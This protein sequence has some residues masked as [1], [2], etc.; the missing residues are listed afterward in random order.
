[1]KYAWILW[2]LAG[3]AWTQPATSEDQPID[4]DLAFRVEA[5]I[6]R[7]GVIE[8]RWKVAEGY[9]L[10]RKKLQI[11][12]SPASCVLEGPELPAG[13]LKDDEYFGR[14]EVYRE[15]FAARLRYSG[16]EPS[17]IGV[18]YQGCGDI[19]VCFPPV[20]RKL[21]L[22]VAANAPGGSPANAVPTSAG[23]VLAVGADA[24]E[25]EIEH[26][27]QGGSPALILISFFGF[28]L[29]L[30]L[31]PCVFPMIPILSGI[32]VKQGGTISRFRAALL[33]GTYVLGMALTY[34]LAGVAAGLSGTMISGALQNPW[35]L[36][37]FAALFVALALSMFGSFELQLPAG[38][39]NRLSAASGNRGGSLGG[40]ALMGALS[41]LIVGPCIAPPLAG[42]LLYI[43]KTGDARL[44]GIALFT[45][46]LGMGVPLMLV[47]IFSREILPKA[48][49]WMNAVTK[50]FGV[51]LLATALWIVSPV[52][53]AWALMLCGAALLIMTAMFL[54]AL[55]PLPPNANGWLRAWKGVGVVFL[56]VGG[57]LLIG[58]L[59]G[60][61]DILQPLSH[62]QQASAAENE[63][64]RFERIASVEELEARIGVAGRP[65]MLDFYADWC[66]SCKEMERETFAAP[67]V[68]K[69]MSGF[70]LLQADVTAN[71]AAHKELLK[72][73]NL[74]GPPA[75]IMFDENGRE[76][77]DKRVVGF[78]P[79]DKF[80]NVL[81]SIQ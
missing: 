48:G 74:F 61:R 49:G 65:V 43:A 67:A 26:L 33:S 70:T 64:S 40:I 15:D 71:S 62:F 34:S 24:S 66:V 41:A 80:R 19:G 47:G 18:T 14:M 81:D 78:M 13:K 5:G 38:L 72:R 7:P 6:A 20:T 56:V 79:A 16:C 2:A 11:K 29:A 53:P 35:V 69:R 63:H 31:T 59:G 42:A 51:A 37:G 32:I 54:H 27:L 9:Y 1:M 36:G 52:L 60:S 3:L 28:G 46:A 75:I 17:D 10:Y 77:R 58:L 30:S 45:M 55:D 50:G 68:E 44:G 21:T 22:G 4:P 57:S 73:F 76:L 25:G 39:Q 23:D 12:L 8:V